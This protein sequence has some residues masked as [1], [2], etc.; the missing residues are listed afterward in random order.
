MKAAFA[1]L[2]LHLALSANP[3]LAND[4][5]EDALIEEASARRGCGGIHLVSSDGRD[6]YVSFFPDRVGARG[7]FSCGSDVFVCACTESGAT[8]RKR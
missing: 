4:Q 1:L 3:A 7:A 8:C 5:T 6:C 2:A